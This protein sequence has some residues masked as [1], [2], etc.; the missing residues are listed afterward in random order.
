M[1]IFSKVISYWLRL[2]SL[3]GAGPVGVCIESTVLRGDSVGLQDMEITHYDS[4]FG[5]TKD[6][7]NGLW[8]AGLCLLQGTYEFVL[9]AT[10]CMVTESLDI[11]IL[12]VASGRHSKV[13]KIIRNFPLTREISV[14]SFVHCYTRELA[15]CACVLV[16]NI[17][18]SGLIQE[19]I[20][21]KVRHKL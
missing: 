16:H 20:I 10:T 8:D 2:I 21:G 18:S 1:L 11:S 5:V 7:S 17:P 14:S 3:L 6:V 15:K 13:F 19:E 9:E 4:M 12:I